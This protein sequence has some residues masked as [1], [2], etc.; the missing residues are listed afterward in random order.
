MAP[1]RFSSDVSV[2]VAI[3]EALSQNCANFTP[4]EKQLLNWNIKHAEYSFGANIDDL[5][6]VS[7]LRRL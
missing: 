1:Y 5:S 7:I 6:M 3:Q 2:Q 4:E